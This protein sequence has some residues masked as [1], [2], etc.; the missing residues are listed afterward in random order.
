MA[1]Q[2]AD[3][4]PPYRAVPRFWHA[5]LV[6]AGI[7]LV[8]LAFLLLLVPTVVE[9]DLNEKATQAPK[10]I[11]WLQVVSGNWPGRPGQNVVGDWTFA[12]SAILAVLLNSVIYIPLCPGLA[13]CI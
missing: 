5:V 2:D 3:P 7:I 1:E 13:V 11:Y 12:F 10:W 9:G 6:A 8:I 4:V